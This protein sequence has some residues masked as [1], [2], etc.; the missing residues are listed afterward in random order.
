[1]TPTGWVWIVF[2]AEAFLCRTDEDLSNWHLARCRIYP[3]LARYKLWRSRR[4]CAL[5]LI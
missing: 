2:S 4:Q 3:L 1:M 5:L